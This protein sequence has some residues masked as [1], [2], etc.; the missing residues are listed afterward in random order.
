M[1]TIRQSLV[2]K[3]LRHYP[4][5]SGAGTLA[6]SKL[7]SVIAGTSRES[8]WCPTN[9]GEI[10]A[11]LD[12]YVGRAAFYCGDLDP[13]VTWVCKALVQ[14]GDTVC[15]VG[16]NIGL[17]TLLLSRLVGQ[18]GQVLAFEPN[19]ACFNALAAAIER[20]QRANICAVQTA[21]GAHT[22][23]LDLL[24]PPGNAGAATLRHNTNSR[25]GKTIRV[26]VRTL[27]DTVAENNIQRIQFLKLDVEGFESNVFKGA[28][29]MLR[30]IRPEAILFEMNDRTTSSLID[31]PVFDVL[32]SHRYAFLYLPKGMLRVRPKAF[33]PRLMGKIPGHDVVAA[34]QGEPFERIAKRLNA[35][36]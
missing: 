13:K 15:D 4:L 5:F 21:L 35:A 18:Q 24:V 11:P 8:V 25:I 16:A 36:H 9:G 2:A 28:E 12:D 33:D 14:P 29:R 23:E 17:V 31:L 30:Q 19:P 7:V 34:P 3:L 22:D 26:P 10:L 20:N 27:D 32:A 1:P 6:N